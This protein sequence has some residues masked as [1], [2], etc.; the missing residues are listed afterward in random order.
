MEVSP[1]VLDIWEEPPNIHERILDGG[2][3]K[4]GQG[5]AGLTTHTYAN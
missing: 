2:K 5:H 3:L 4:V 1:K